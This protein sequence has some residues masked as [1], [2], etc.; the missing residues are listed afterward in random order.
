MYKIHNFCTEMFSQ[1]HWFIEIKPN[2]DQLLS[3]GLRKMDLS[4]IFDFWLNCPELAHIYCYC[5]IITHNYAIMTQK[6]SK[7]SKSGF[8]SMNLRGWEKTSVQKLC[9]FYTYSLYY[10]PYTFFDNCLNQPTLLI[11][12]LNNEKRFFN[13]VKSS[14]KCITFT[15]RSNTL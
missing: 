14:W 7:W 11:H 5:A 3:L 2:L 8:I 15:F 12:Y 10:V 6:Q 9:I 13:S 4:R 1:L